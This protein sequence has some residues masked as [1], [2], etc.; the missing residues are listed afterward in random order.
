MTFNRCPLRSQPRFLVG[1]ASTVV[2]QVPWLITS[3]LDVVV[4][5]TGA[6]GAVEKTVMTVADVLCNVTNTRGVTEVTMVDHD[7]E[8]MV[9]DHCG[10][11]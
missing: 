9:K 2:D 7:L 11:V 6:G 3:D 8:P 4:L 5:V 1:D 10:V